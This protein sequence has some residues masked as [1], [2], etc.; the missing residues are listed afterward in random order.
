V[1]LREE[2]PSGGGSGGGG[3][4][5]GGGGGG[6]LLNREAR[7]EARSSRR[8]RP[9]TKDKAGGTPFQAKVKLGANQM[10]KWIYVSSDGFSFAF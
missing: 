5:G 4:G 8:R 1:S 9:Q 3:S 6:G 10:D 7:I 2:G